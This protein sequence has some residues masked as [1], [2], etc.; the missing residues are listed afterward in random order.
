MKNLFF[1]AIASAALLLSACTRE[2]NC[3]LLPPSYFVN[4]SKNSVNWLSQ[5]TAETLGTDSLMIVGSQTDERLLLR[6]KF[7][8]KGVYTFHNTQAFYFT[9][10]GQDV[11]TSDY[12]V[13]ESAVS[14]LEVLDYNVS[15]KTISGTYSLRLKKVYGN[16]DSDFP[17]TAIFANGQFSVKLP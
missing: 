15:A 5:G 12:Q 1:I 11:A 3:C 2:K 4:A 7:T 17:A 6:L 8:G 13:D 10:V 16:P 14:T 9:T